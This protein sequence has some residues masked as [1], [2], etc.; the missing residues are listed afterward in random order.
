MTSENI[1]VNTSIV[2]DDQ[3]NKEIAN[4]SGVSLGN[5]YRWTLK[6]VG[7]GHGHGHFRKNGLG[8]TKRHC[9][10]I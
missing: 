1:V 9:H 5:V 10:I 4:I 6:F 3:S 8:S 2:K 7:F